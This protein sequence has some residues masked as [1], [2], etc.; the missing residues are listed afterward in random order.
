M[1]FLSRWWLLSG[2]KLFLQ[3]FNRLDIVGVLMIFGYRCRWHLSLLQYFLAVS[4]CF[5]LKLAFSLNLALNFSLLSIYE[6]LFALQML[7]DTFFPG[8]ESFAHLF[9]LATHGFWLERAARCLLK[10]PLLL[11]VN[12]ALTG[13]FGLPKVRLVI[14]SAGW[15]GVRR[16]GALDSGRLWRS[17]T[18]GLILLQANSLI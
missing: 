11:Q 18:T 8:L 4:A 6:I 17:F 14:G 13:L 10:Y 5:R 9:G 16:I 3:F 1:S 7:R 12:D 2:S 15:L